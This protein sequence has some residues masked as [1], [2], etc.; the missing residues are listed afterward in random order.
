MRLKAKWKDQHKMPKLLKKDLFYSLD[1]MEEDAFDFCMYLQD[2]QSDI[3]YDAILE[4][5]SNII[6]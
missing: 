4:Y 3:N 1:M 5:L 2:W 6:N